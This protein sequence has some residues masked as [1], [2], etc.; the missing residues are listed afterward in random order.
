MA[1]KFSK[2][3]AGLVGLL[4]VFTGCASIGPGTIDRDHFDYGAS[5]SNSMSEQL[6]MNMVRLRYDEPP[7]FLT[8]S[9]V[10]SQYQREV[11][12]SLL[13]GYGTSLAGGNSVGGG[14]NASWADR[15]TI[16]YTPI[17]GREFAQNLLTP[18][19]LRALFGLLQ[20][21]WTPDLVLRLTVLSIN[22][23]ENQVARPGRRQAADPTFNEIIRLWRQLRNEHALGVR[24]AAE[25]KTDEMVLFFR[26]DLTGETRAAARRL[27]VLLG[28][29]PELDEV[30]LVTGLIP[31][32]A[33][34]VAFLTG[35]I[36]DIMLNL[37]WRFDVP[38]AH[39]E[40]GRTA[41]T[42][43]EGPEDGEAPIQVGVAKKRPDYAWMA[44][45]DRGHWFYIDDRDRRSK[46]S[47]GFVQMLLS[48]VETE[49]GARGPVVTI[50]N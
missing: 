10:I 4:V 1:R 34:E 22:G 37:A 12:L 44:V 32:D 21:G 16:T 23:N 14:A 40:E 8:V 3:S 39:V 15:P 38:E 27:H 6:L 35:S 20:A 47:F 41:P 49:Q 31:D 43:V 50:G 5:I 33:G 13:G 45:H 26:R 2:F 48:L 18:L 17:S 7:M 28:L 30:K 11:G 36:M 29:D 24:N 25:G 42:F 9:S 46:R 19:T